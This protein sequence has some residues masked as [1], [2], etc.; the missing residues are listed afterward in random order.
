MAKKHFLRHAPTLKDTKSCERIMVKSP[1][2]KAGIQIGSVCQRDD[3][4]WGSNSIGQAGVGGGYVYGHKRTKMA[5]LKDAL[6]NYKSYI[7]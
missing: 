4:T 2:V 6:K 3:G 5:A 7:G 1:Y